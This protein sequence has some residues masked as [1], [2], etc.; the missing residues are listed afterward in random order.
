MVESNY[1]RKATDFERSKTTRKFPLYVKFSDGTEG[2][3][4]LSEFAGKEV[5]AL[6]ND[7]SQF[8]QVTIGSSGELVW[9]ED[10]DLDGLGLYLRLTGKK[11]EDVLP[12]LREFSDA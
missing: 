6:W 10:V 12:T 9:S 11:P 1:G 5:L 3:V 2:K 4:D 8:E 7:Y